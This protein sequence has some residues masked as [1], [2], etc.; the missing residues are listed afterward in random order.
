MR[1][2]KRLVAARLAGALAMVAALGG[3]GLFRGRGEHRPKTAVLGERIPVLNTENDDFRNPP[4][5][6]AISSSS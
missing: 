6:R 4:A 3:C 2:T 1:M 5:Y